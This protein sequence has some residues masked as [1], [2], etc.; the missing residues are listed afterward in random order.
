MTRNKWFVG[1]TAAVLGLAVCGSAWAQTPTTQVADGPGR[2][3]SSTKGS[4]LMYSKVELR[5]NA[6]GGL[7]QDTILEMT[8]D[9]P[10]K[11]CVQLYFVNGDEP[12]D[13]IFA[14]SPP[15]QVA[16]GEPGWNWVDC[17][18]CLTQNQPT[19]WSAATGLPAGCQPWSILDP[20][21]GS[22]HGR[23]DPK[24]PGQRMLRGFVYAWAVDN[25]G[26]QIR[27]NHLSGSATL[28]NYADTTAWEY[29]AWS[30]QVQEAFA[31]GAM[32]GDRCGRI[33]MNGLVYA[34]PYDA[35]LFN[36]FASGSTAF[37]SGSNMV[38][39]DT[40]L[41]LHPA[42]AD[43]RQD[44]KGPI[45]TKA[46][47]D[48][49]NQ[50]EAGRSGTTRCITCWDQTLLSQ[51]ANPNNFLIGNLGT[52]KGKA[53]IH[54]M[55]SD[56]CDLNCFSDR[57]NSSDEIGI[58]DIL[59]LLGIDWVC[60]YEAALMG[61]SAKFLAFSGASTGKAVAGSNLVGMGS[62]N[63]HIKYDLVAPP[64]EAIGE[65]AGLRGERGFGKGSLDRGQLADDAESMGPQVVPAE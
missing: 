19:Y 11:V 38:S 17:S 49:W 41:T 40:S 21:G 50:N 27:W 42:T 45:T 22:G 44:S 35:L 15:M 52:D 53:R 28:V 48:I 46:H 47:F 37:S 1:S 36:F 57:R 10:G 51:Y 58:E 16:E 3:S 29:N 60:S 8:N 12:L 39:V 23:P 2:V 25:A 65:T 7:T 64:G 59:D 31:H 55:R 63:A 20:D 9:Y 14:G 34:A 32:A 62:Q 26:C 61:V 6:A 54:G 30:Y 43:L 13:P 5:W 18:F 4:L 56:V 33:N 24:N